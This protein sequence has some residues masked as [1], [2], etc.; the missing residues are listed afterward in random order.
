MAQLFAALCYRPEGVL[1]DSCRVHW[2]FSLTLSFQPHYGPGVDSASNR[3]QYQGYLLG[4]G[5]G[6]RYMGLGTLSPSCADCL[7]IWGASKPPG[8]L[9]ACPVLY[10]GLLYLLI[11]EVQ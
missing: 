8:A 2:D 11:H 5:K 9:R 4:G 3:E 7:E 1:F 10:E 6:G